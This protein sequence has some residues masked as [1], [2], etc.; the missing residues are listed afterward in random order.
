MHL[1]VNSASTDFTKT[2]QLLKYQNG[3]QLMEFDLI[4]VISK[5]Q[6]CYQPLP[7]KPDFILIQ[8]ATTDYTELPKCLLNDVNQNE[9]SLPCMFSDEA[10]PL[11]ACRDLAYQVPDCEHTSASGS[12]CLDPSSEGWIADCFND[13]DMSFNM[14]D[15][16]ASGTPDIQIDITDIC[17]TP[18]EYDANAVK[19]HPVH[20][21]GNVVFKG[22]KSFMRTPPKQAS[23]VVKP[24]AFIKPCGVHGDT[25]L[26]DI[27]LKIHTPPKLL[28][29]NEDLSDS[30]L[31][32]AFSGKPVVG[33]TKIH[34]D[35]GK[36]SITIMR[37]KG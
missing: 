26:K 19:K 12:E 10:T 27:N 11:K 35:G 17:N 4:I 18:P 7:I 20:P 28:Q 31:T 32:S 21:R 33:R 3:M 24:F 15:I 34:T 2:T 13:V 36:G 6:L 1:L 5:Q 9:Q 8:L 23:S 37:T 29:S 16:S 25:T 22:R 14:E 30:C